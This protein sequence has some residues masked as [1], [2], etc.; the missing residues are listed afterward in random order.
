MKRSLL[1][2]AASVLPLAAPS[3]SRSETREQWIELGTRVHG[4]FGAFIPVGIRI[5][6]DALERLK[7]DKRGLSVTFYNGE[8]PPCPCVADGVVMATQ[9]R[10]GQ[11]TSQCPVET[12]RPAGVSNTYVGRLATGHLSWNKSDAP[13]RFEAATAPEGLFKSE[14]LPRMLLIILHNPKTSRDFLLS[15]D[16]TIASSRSPLPSA[17]DGL[18]KSH[19]FRQLLQF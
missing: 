3:A 11:G 12:A 15:Y 1:I 6:L 2:A 16:N 4:G 18:P 9:T 17:C 8:K 7:A 14:P 19:S 5:G 13:A 10:P